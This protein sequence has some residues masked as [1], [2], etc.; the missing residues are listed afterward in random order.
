MQISILQVVDSHLA[1]APVAS[2]AV[3]DKVASTD[4]VATG[5]GRVLGDGARASEQ[6][7]AH[8]A[9]LDG[10]GDLAHDFFDDVKDLGVGVAH[11]VDDGDDLLEVF[12]IVTGQGVDGDADLGHKL[13][14][15]GTE[16]VGLD[17]VGER[18]VTVARAVILFVSVI[19]V[20]VTTG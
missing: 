1:L 9:G 7:S 10:G 3:G 11:Q 20:R 15:K 4:G 5:L 8:G 17:V 12:T 6:A 16:I 14:E 2:L 18:E 19:V 13:L